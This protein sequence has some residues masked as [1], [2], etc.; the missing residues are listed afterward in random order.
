M[1]VGENGSAIVEG[2]KQGLTP[3]DVV[4]D[5]EGSRASRSAT[6]W[7]QRRKNRGLTPLDVTRITKAIGE[8]SAAFHSKFF[9]FFHTRGPPLFIDSRGD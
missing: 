6:L 8:N 9:F 2:D 7:M 5:N 4:E 3:G 1:L